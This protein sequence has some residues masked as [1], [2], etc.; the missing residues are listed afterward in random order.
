VA[1]F[2]ADATRAG[3]WKRAGKLVDE[4]VQL[5]PE[6]ETMWNDNDVQSS[7]EGTKYLHK[8]A[9][10]QI[11]LDYSSFAVD[12]QPS[13]SMMIFTPATPADADRVRLLLQLPANEV[14]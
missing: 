2:R 6:F 13:L 8:P 14:P 5:S 3:A 11:A 1:V 9:V 12:G 7:G 10:G 4:L